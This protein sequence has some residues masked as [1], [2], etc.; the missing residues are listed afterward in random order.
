MKIIVL[1]LVELLGKNTLV[2][3]IKL[4][5]YCLKLINFYFYGVR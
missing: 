3:N 2:K 4:L 5:V 1:K